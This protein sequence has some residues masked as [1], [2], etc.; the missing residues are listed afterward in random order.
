MIRGMFYSLRPVAT[1]CNSETSL[2]TGMV[3]Q[4]LPLKS[5]LAKAGD[6]SFMKMT[7]PKP[8][9]AGSTLS[10]RVTSTIQS[11]GVEDAMVRGDGCWD[12]PRQSETRTVSSSAGLAHA[13][14]YVRSRAD[15]D[16]IKTDACN[17]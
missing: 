3:T 13:L 1:R 5:H 14:T 8:P 16:E 2:P 6:M 7:C 17:R 4:V 9:N 10:R 15:M 11:T 12:E